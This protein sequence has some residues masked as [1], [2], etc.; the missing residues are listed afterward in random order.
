VRVATPADAPELLVLQ[1]ACWMPEAR[2]SGGWGIPPLDESLEE[3][4]EG[5]GAWTTYAVRTASAHAGAGRL[6]ASVRGRVRPG[7]DAVWETGRLMVAPDPQGRGLGRELLELAEATAPA[8]VTTLWINTGAVSEANQRR[9]RRA[10]YRLLPGEG[11]WP[12]TV[13]LVKPRRPR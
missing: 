7:D 9:Y 12:G 3:V 4:A 11:T 6:V 13:D 2:L 8:S 10:G 1:R 5:I